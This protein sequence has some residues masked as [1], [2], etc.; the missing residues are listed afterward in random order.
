MIMGLT[1][2]PFSK[3]REPIGVTSKASGDVRRADLELAKRCRDGDADAFEELYRQHAGRLYNLTFRMVGSEPEAEDL[4]QE[5]FLHAFRKL[6]SFRGDSSLGTWLYRLGMNQCLDYLRGRQAKMSHATD[7]LDDE[8]AA[9]PA[10]PMPATPIAVNRMDLERAI[11]KLPGGCRAAFL[12]HDV[13][14]FEH[15]EVATI[16]GVS[17]GTSKSQVHKARMKLRGLLKRT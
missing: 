16:L 10:A 2:K 4:L 9:E 13:E 17:E 7:S 15:H 6:D 5:V 12:L 8:D 3:Q 1:A 11:A 14:G